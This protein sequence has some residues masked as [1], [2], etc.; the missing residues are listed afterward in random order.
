MNP[1]AKEFTPSPPK[2]ASSNND[3]DIHKNN[4]D[5]NSENTNEDQNK[6]KMSNGRRE[7]SKS[8]KDSKVSIQCFLSLSYFL[9]D[10]SMLRIPMFCLS[11]KIFEKSRRK[12]TIDKTVASTTLEVKQQ[13]YI[14]IGDL[15]FWF[16]GIVNKNER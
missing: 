2:K 6:K 14:W 5:R 15:A 3:K 8:A 12:I 11:L 10:I 4:L 16:F 13:K 1:Q 9:E 7:G